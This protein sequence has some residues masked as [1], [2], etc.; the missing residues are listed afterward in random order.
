MK[1]LSNQTSFYKKINFSK[2]S[3]LFY[4]FCILKILEIL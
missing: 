3:K 2:I 4:Y 1:N